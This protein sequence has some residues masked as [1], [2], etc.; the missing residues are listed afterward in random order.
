MKAT[1]E[2]IV[3]AIITSET[4]AEAAEKIGLSESQLYQ[5]LK[6]EELQLLYKERQIE[7]C[8]RI[9]DNMISHVTQAV[10]TMIEIMED[11][12][13]SPS[14]RLSA[15]NSLLKQVA[16]YR[17]ITNSMRSSIEFAEFEKSFWG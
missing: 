7:V 6:D 1:N 3:T 12:E 4:N 8:A 5:R 9:T 16:P 14:I 10:K 2:E 11:Q 17:N 15:A 13:N